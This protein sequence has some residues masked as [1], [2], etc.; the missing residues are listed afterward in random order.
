MPGTVW[1]PMAFLRQ[2]SATRARFALCVVALAS[3]TA[4]SACG[5]SGPS[6]PTVR[7]EVGAIIANGDTALAK[8]LSLATLSETY[9]GESHDFARAASQ[10]HALTYPSTVQGDADAVVTALNRLSV[11][12]FQQAVASSENDVTKQVA[13]AKK[14]DQDQKA[15]V[16]ASDALRRALGL[17]PVETKTSTTTSSPAILK[18]TSG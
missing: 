16:K 14:T 2:T 17:P 4:M 3:A 8:D 11:D 10:L 6:I 5:S 15:E 18:P 9:A 7:H 13:L 12:A 1:R